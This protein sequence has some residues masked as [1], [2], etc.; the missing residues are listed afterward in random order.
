MACPFFH[1]WS[2]EVQKCIYYDDCRQGNDVDI[3][4]GNSDA[5]CNKMIQLATGIKNLEKMI[6]E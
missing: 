1:D 2:E 4:G 3:N 5:W 6:E